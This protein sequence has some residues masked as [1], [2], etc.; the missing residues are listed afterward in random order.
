MVM[1]DIMTNENENNDNI[2]I[3]EAGDRPEL[4]PHVVLKGNP[5]NLSALRG[6]DAQTRSIFFDERNNNSND[7]DEDVTP[8]TP[9]LLME[10]SVFVS[11]MMTTDADADDE[12][13]DENKNNNNNTFIQ[14][15]MFITNTQILFVAIERDQSQY[16]LA[17]GAACIVLH[18]MTDEPELSVY[19]QLSSSSSSSVGEQQQQQQQ[20]PTETSDG[21]ETTSKE[22]ERDK[23]LER[24]D[25]LLVVPPQF[26]DGQFDDAIEENDD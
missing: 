6:T 5:A 23:M 1:E 10:S 16:D 4:Y 17:I 24:L 20:P 18:A 25:N 11:L 3:I 19:L 8:S 2:L 26:E 21:T 14:G 15:E 22:E 7:D 13:E 12:N 9:P